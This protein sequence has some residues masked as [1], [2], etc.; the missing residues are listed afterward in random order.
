MK[1]KR[2]R[3]TQDYVL[4][5]LKQ[6]LASKPPRWVRILSKFLKLCGRGC[7]VLAT[8]LLGFV[9]QSLF[10]NPLW[11]FALGTILNL[12]LG[13]LVLTAIGAIFWLVAEIMSEYEE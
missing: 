5:P 8:S 6:T 7:W 2:P 9:A 11:P 3:V 10:S 4:V 13:G 1:N 12:T